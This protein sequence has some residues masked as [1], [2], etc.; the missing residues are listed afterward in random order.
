MILQ[1]EA[2]VMDSTPHR[3][4]NLATKV[5]DVMLEMETSPMTA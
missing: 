1:V 4:M 2:T 3:E 5:M